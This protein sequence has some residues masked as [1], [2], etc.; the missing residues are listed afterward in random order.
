MGSRYT[1]AQKNAIMMWRRKNPEAFLELKKKYDR[2]YY[3][4][5]R[6]KRLEYQKRYTA[7]KKQQHQLQSDFIDIP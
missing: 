2:E 3:L 4:R 6:E 1:L 7:L 5:H